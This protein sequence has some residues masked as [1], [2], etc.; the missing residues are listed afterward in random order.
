MK[1][2]KWP[3]LLMIISIVG[4]NLMITSLKERQVKATSSNNLSS[5]PL[6]KKRENNQPTYDIWGQTISQIEAEQLMKTKKGQALLSP[7]NGAVKIDSSLLQL[8]K[9]SFYEETFGNEGFITDIMGAFDGPITLP[10]IQKAVKELEG[11]GTTNL[12]VELANTVTIGGKTFKKGRKVDTGLDVAKGTNKVLGMPIKYSEGKM[13]AGISCLACHATVD[14]NSKQIIEGAPNSDL[15][16]GLLIAFAKNSAAYFTHTDISSLKKYMNNF[17][18]TIKTSDDKTAVLPNPKMLEDAVDRNVLKWPKGNFDSTIDMKSNPAQI[19]DSFTLGDFPYGWSGH[20]MA[21]PFKGL[22]TFNNNVHAQNSDSLSQ[23][24]VSRELF[25]IDKE[26]YMG[27][28]LQSAANPKYRYIPNQG[29]KPSEF[30]VAVDPT[31]GIPGVNELI[32]PPSFPKVTLIAPDGLIA[33]SPGYKVNEQNNAMSAWQNTLVPPKSEIKVDS[34]TMQLGRS[35]FKRASCITCH[36]GSDFTNNRI[37]SAAKIGTEPSRA[38]ALKKT[39]KIWGEAFIYSPDT[40]VPVPKNAK[41]LK[42]PTTQLD[43]EQIDLA[44]AKGE[45]PGGYKVP[46]LIGLYWTAPYLHDG[47]VAVGPNSNT[48]LGFPGTLMKGVYPDPVNSLRALVDKKQRERV[49]AAN[50]LANLQQVHVQ[51]IG[52]EYWVDASTGFSNQEQDA[53]IRYLLT[54]E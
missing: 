1:R 51:G 49:I 25:G 47:G 5:S 41:I 22:S 18:H 19:P 33:S 45:S 14:S 27:T 13:K 6:Q 35:V 3:V 24:E 16:A 23:S 21:G 28:I 37:I 34:K 2:R 46:S 48:Q 20:A 12:Q 54:L 30:F 43:P 17:N 8:G 36:A 50:R 38:Q 10:N 53:L 44:F 32:K 40:P 39:E 7:Q 15:N 11:K 29:K 31:P 26:V 42:V 4:I 9:K 52:H